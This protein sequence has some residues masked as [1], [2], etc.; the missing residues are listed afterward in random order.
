MRP[1]KC[2]VFSGENGAG[3]RLVTVGLAWGTLELQWGLCY[4]GLSFG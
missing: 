3:C 2:C 4:A 1:I